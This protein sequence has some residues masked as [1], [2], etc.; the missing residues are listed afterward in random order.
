M[1]KILLTIFLIFLLTNNLAFAKSIKPDAEEGNIQ[2][3]FLSPLKQ[4]KP[5]NECKNS[6]CK[7]LLHS[8]NNTKESIDF[9]IYGINNQDKIFNALVKAQRR[10][11]KVR[12]VTDLNEKNRNIYYDTYALMHKIPTYNTD[13][14]SIESKNIPDYEYKLDYQGALMHNKFFIF[15]NQKVFT[16]STNI[17]SYCLTGYNSN[18]AILIDSPIVASV[19][20]QEFE[21][22]YNGKFHNEKSA[23][24]NNENIKFD[25][26]DISIYFSPINKATVE[27]I[28]PLIK[29]SESYIYIPAFYLTRKSIVYELIEAYKRGVEVK[30]IV[31]ET[32]VKGK[33]VDI[34]FMK[35]NNLRVKVENW[36]GKMHMKSMI[37]DDEILVIGSMNFTKQG[38]RM[39]DE[40]CLVIKNAPILTK[41]YKE[42]FLELWN[43]IK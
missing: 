29:K 13:Y 12:W 5:K 34:D 7:A 37:I 28:I 23:I 16:G 1:K 32:S 4:K 20:K 33:Y 17:S 39:N 8:I 31:D 22:M 41:K 15:D 30:I 40:N 42:H 9:A 10:G 27:Q 36:P 24:S 19:Y 21:Q 43:S 3:F 6:A 14:D 26:V 35:K 18:V 25:N 2:L 11:V 38:E